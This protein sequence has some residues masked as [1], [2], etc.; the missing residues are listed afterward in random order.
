MKV[1]NKSQIIKSRKPK[2]HSKKRGRPK[3][4]TSKGSRSSSSGSNTSSSS[5]SFM[6]NNQNLEGKNILLLGMIYMRRN[7]PEIYEM[8]GQ[9]ERDGQRCV[10]LEQL[11]QGTVYTVDTNRAPTD[12]YIMPGRHCRA[13]AETWNASVSR[14]FRAK[15]GQAFGDIQFS[16]IGL[17]YYHFPAAYAR[18]LLTPQFF[19]QSL[20]G[21][22]ITNFLLPRGVV[23]LPNFDFVEENLAQSDEIQRLYNITV[24]ANPSEYPLYEASESIIDSLQQLPDG[25]SHV[26]NCQK[27]IRL[28]RKT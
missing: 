18:L 25:F 21:Y 28:E 26:A 27:K 16:M 4:K 1:K 3:K 23:W 15:I 20:P 2:K 9:L 7:I 12:P 10:A 11:T 13:H 6:R 19:Q 17:D 8:S 14:N 22:A 24:T 5:V